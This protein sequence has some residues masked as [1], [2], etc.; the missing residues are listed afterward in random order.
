[1]ENLID[2]LVDLSEE[3]EDEEFSDLINELTDKLNCLIVT[4]LL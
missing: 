3:F 2:K 1:M 4:G